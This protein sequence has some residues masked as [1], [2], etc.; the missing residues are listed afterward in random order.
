MAADFGVHFHESDLPS[1][2]EWQGAIDALGF[3]LQL[4]EVPLL[5]HSGL[6]PVA[7]R[8]DELNTGFEFEITRE[9]GRPDPEVLGGRSLFAHFRCFSD[10]WPAAVCAAA[11]FAKV[12][13][14]VFE[15]PY[16]EYTFDVEAVVELAKKENAEGSEPS[17]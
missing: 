8:C 5:E 11:A 14:G 4:V 9:W 2:A 15:D 10:E 7:F 13:N 17:S 16:G 12:T 6:L 3:A 1:Q